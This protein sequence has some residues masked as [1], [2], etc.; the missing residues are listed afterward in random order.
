M[1]GFWK[2]INNIPINILQFLLTKV[3]L[4]GKIDMVS[5]LKKNFKIYTE[6]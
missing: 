5:I 4:F 1:N 2:K 3:K 6:S